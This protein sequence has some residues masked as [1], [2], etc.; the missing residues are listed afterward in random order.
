MSVKRAVITGIGAV[1]PGGIGWEKTWDALTAPRSGIRSISLFEA[2]GYRTQ[3][4]GEVA[5]FDAR[6]FISD[7]L[8]DGTERFTHLALAAAKLA[9]KDSGLDLPPDSTDAG[10]VLGCGMGGL[11]YF[12]LQA[13]NYAKKGPGSIRPGSIP[14]I[15]PNAAAAYIASSWKLRGPNLTISTACSSSN[16]AVGSALD[17]IRS[18]RCQF[19]LCG[20]TESLLS[21]V[22]FGAFDSIRVMSNKNDRPAQAC[23]PFDK[24]RDGFVMGEGAI[25]FV[26]EEAE[27]A[28]A[29]QAKIYAEVAGYGASNGAYNILAP[30]PDGR[31]ASESMAGALRDAKLAPEDVQYIHAHGTGTIS[32]DAAE[33]QGIKRT[34]QTHAK[35]L[36]VSSTKPVTGHMLG[37]AG[38]LGIMVCAL[39]ISLGI[40]PPTMNYEI[41]DEACDLDYVP[42]KARN[43]RVDVALSNAFAFGSNNATIV[44]KREAR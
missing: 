18:S 35:K 16:H 6:A 14:R 32:N 10:V 43:A 44:V 17:L 27:H 24:S 23:R 22:T 13:D 39:A 1:T 41:P 29:R 37:S 20:G 15:M 11:P 19:V 25:I 3:I 8:T 5:D 12:E 34:F 7:K 38:A 30:E 33:T 4:A 42:G 9:L 40:V 2:S 26:L 31:E 21:P 28:R 36:M